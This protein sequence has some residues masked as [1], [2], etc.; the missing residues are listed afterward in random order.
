MEDDKRFRSLG[1]KGI[2]PR[3][4]EELPG[5]VPVKIKGTLLGAVAVAGAETAAQDEKCAEAAVV[6][7]VGST[8]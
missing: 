5:A 6:S 8:E 2:F 4:M 7:I 3:D 1:T